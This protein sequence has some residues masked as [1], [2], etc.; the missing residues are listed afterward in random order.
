ME[1]VNCVPRSPQQLVDENIEFLENIRPEDVEY[2]ES[3][4]KMIYGKTKSASQKIL[5]ELRTVDLEDLYYVRFPRDHS[6]VRVDEILFRWQIL[7]YNK[8]GNKLTKY[9]EIMANQV[10][11]R[12]V[13]ITTSTD[14][15]I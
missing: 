13:E 5:N 15:K 2:S 12:I 1:N 9:S 10:L 14:H 11:D 7:Y 8:V 3:S 4:M 6:V